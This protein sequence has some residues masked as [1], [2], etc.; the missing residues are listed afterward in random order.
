MTKDKALKLALEALEV[1]NSCVD[2]YYIPKGKTQLPEVE[3]AITAIKETLAQEQEP[4]ALPLVQF[5]KVA[6]GIEV[7]YDVFGGVDIRLGGEF[8]YV[9]I[10]YD[11]RYTHNA[12]RKAL[13]KQIVG[14]LTTPPQRTW[15]GLIN[16]EIETIWRK[17]EAGD[18]H[19]CV[20]PFAEKL[21]AKLKEK[22]CAG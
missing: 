1:A 9:H 19:D 20:L 22:N 7:G 6:E 3:E 2:G 13:A 15:V 18:F 12:E 11:Y 4:V 14:L 21:E 8:V 16:E 10:N 17:V 5:E